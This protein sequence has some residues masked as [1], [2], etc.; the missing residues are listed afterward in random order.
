MK[1]A[2]EEVARIKGRKEGSK[3]GRKK[4]M[5]GCKRSVNAQSIDIEQLERTKGIE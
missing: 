5:K 2:V 3:E 4:G 1:S